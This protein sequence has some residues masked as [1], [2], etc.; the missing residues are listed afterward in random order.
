MSYSED[1]AS[2]LADVQD[3]GA[4]VAFSLVSAGTHD[5][6]TDTW[7]GGSTTTVTGSA[8][9]TAGNPERYKA[10]E[11]VES[12]APTLFFTP[13]TYGSLPDQGSTVSWGGV[14]YTVRDVDPVAPDGTA[15]GAYVVI[16]R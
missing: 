5:P 10:L 1:H 6:A 8:V 15:I 11:L 14:T 16:A 13:D 9:R 7:S 3:A 12:E 4:S 2:A